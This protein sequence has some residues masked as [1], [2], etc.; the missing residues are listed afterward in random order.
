MAIESIDK[1][2]TSHLQLLSAK[3]KKT[4]LRVVKS[5]TAEN[6]DWWDEIGTAQQVAVDKALAE[7]NA[8]KLEPHEEVM[9]K[10]KK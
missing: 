6:K 4:V 5:F 1:E 2:I 9:K 8:G 3:Q 7:M 10:Y